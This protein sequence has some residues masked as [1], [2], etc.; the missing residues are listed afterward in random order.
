MNTRHSFY[1]I[2]ISLLMVG[3]RRSA[4]QPKPFDYEDFF[5]KILNQSSAG[6]I[7]GW[8]DR[9]TH[10]IQLLYTQIDRDS[11]NVPQFTSYHLEL[12]S[13]RY[14][15]PGEA[16]YPSIAA[17]S[18]AKLNLIY[19]N[20]AYG[21]PTP[22]TPL[23]IDE[24]GA[25][26]YPNYN[27]SMLPDSLPTVRKYVDNMLL[28][29]QPVAYNRLYEF[30]GRNY[31]FNTLQQKGMTSANVIERYDAPEFDAY[32]NRFTNPLRLQ[33]AGADTIIYEQEKMM[34]DERSH[35]YLQG[36][37]R[38]RAYIRPDGE[39]INQPFNFGAHNYMSLP[40]LQHSL[41]VLLFPEY[42]DYDSGYVL[43]EENYQYLNTRLN[44]KNTNQRGQGFAQQLPSS[45]HV[46]G[47]MGRGYGFTTD[48][49]YVFDPESGVEFLISAVI[50]TNAN[51][52]FED[53]EYEYTQV[54]DPFLGAYALALYNHEIKRPRQV[55][56]DFSWFFKAMQ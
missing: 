21:Q 31:I 20:P 44:R 14:F 46:M 38:G 35:T 56:P 1:L 3:C 2:V 52:V 39:V 13:P 47:I 55:R 34:G 24:G 29:A 10:E 26:Q 19:M 12:D 22:E 30:L 6:N 7:P 18:L 25:P 17:L 51:D 40:D 5:D 49:A 54:A 4:P 43:T 48:C 28:R 8:D 32:S 50:Y 53:G 45:C 11:F 42:T 36:V 33:E 23:L 9:R 27:S 16:I 37:L 15:F 41:R